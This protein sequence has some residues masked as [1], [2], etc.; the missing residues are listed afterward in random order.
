MRRLTGLLVTGLLGGFVLSAIAANAAAF[1]IVYYVRIAS[2]TA[3]DL[4]EAIAHGPIPVRVHGKP[5]ADVAPD[6]AAARIG[7]AMAGANFGPK[8]AF[9]VYDGATADGYVVVVRF[10]DGAPPQRLCADAVEHGVGAGYAMAFCKD[11][12]A[13][14]YLAGHAGSTDI[15]GRAF[16]N[17]FAGAAVELLPFE[18]PHY[19]GDCGRR[20]CP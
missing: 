6:A 8:T 20:G 3:A 4:A 15:D 9:R 10:G 5:A 17:A 7:Q 11:G 13:L 16:R 12:A 2:Y 19:R 1:D 18:N 14:S